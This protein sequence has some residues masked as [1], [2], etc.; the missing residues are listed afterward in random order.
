MLDNAKRLDKR[1]FMIYNFKHEY[2]NKFEV[3][4]VNKMRA[5][6]YYIPFRNPDVMYAN[7]YLTER[8]NSDMI[9]L[10]NG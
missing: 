7:D 10:L 1:Y 6:S 2:F 9:T 5:R 8:Y 4:E 3:F